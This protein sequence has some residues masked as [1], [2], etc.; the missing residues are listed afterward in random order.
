M[1]TPYYMA[2]EQAHGDRANAR[3]DIFSLGAMFYE[4]ATGK[5][6][7]D[8]ASDYDV[9]E[10]I[11]HAR[12]EPPEK[13]AD[14]NMPAHIVG[15]IKRAMDP[16]PAKR[17]ADCRELSEALTSG[18]PIKAAGI[19][20]TSFGG[21]TGPTRAVGAASMSHDGRTKWPLILALGAGGAA[22]AGVAIFLATKGG[23]DPKSGGGSAGS[24]S[25]VVQGGGASGS[26][27][28]DLIATAPVVDAGAD[29][30]AA[31]ADAAVD[32]EEIDVPPPVDAAVIDA[33]PKAAPP[34]SPSYSCKGRW[35]G[36]EI[37]LSI[38]RSSGTCGTIAFVSGLEC[39]GS[40]TGC[41]DGRNFRASYYCPIPSIGKAYS[42]SLSMPCT[43]NDAAVSINVNGS[44]T[45]KYVHR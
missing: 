28:N 16:D 13:L 10:N 35:G 34:P 6:P 31:S 14:P 20:A 2:P 26:A 32:A 7:F 4:M 3:S 37:R 41:S 12:F 42:G 45:T 27:G 17:W 24:G 21:K 11:V 29:P 30:W 19:T 18:K 22:L 25:S 36:S 5:A 40:L 1:G 9:M 38:T 23:D 8:G 39:S 43:K 15:A 44:Y 33:P